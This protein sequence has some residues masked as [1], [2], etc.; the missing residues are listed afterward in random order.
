MTKNPPLIS[1]TCYKQRMMKSWNK[2]LCRIQCKIT[3]WY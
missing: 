2:N 1:P 3:V